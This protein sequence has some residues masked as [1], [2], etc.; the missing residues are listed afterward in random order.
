MGWGGGHH[1]NLEVSDDVVLR[2][3]FKSEL[4]G[5]DTLMEVKGRL[6]LDI[7]GHSFPLPLHF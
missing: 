5:V 3:T 6:G 1:G 2:S 7:I 4:S